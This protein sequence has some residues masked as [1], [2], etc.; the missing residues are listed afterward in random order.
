MHDPNLKTALDVSEDEVRILNASNFRKM[1][2]DS[3]VSTTHL[4]KKA[5]MLPMDDPDSDPSLQVK[6]RKGPREIQQP[7]IRGIM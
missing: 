4:F 6:S 5:V 1:H 7:F 2:V 3:I